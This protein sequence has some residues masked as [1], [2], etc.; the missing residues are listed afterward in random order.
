M[1]RE[2]LLFIKDILDNMQKA[3]IFVEGMNY[4]EFVDD[5]K[6]IY[7]VI[8]CI[9]IIGEAV[10]HIPDSIKD[11]FPEVPWRDIA[12]MRDK[13]IHFYFGIN[14]KTVWLVIK[15]DIPIVKPYFAKI[16]MDIEKND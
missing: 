11:Q 3:E 1:K 14:P 13:I 10:K 5:E 12:G 16:F 15:E 2:V 6:T 4:M 7:A 8:R 9:E